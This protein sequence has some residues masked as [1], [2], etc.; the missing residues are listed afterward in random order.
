MRWMLLV[1]LLLAPVAGCGGS[2]QKPGGKVFCQSYE[3]N[4]LPECQRNC[5]EGK[6]ISNRE[7]IGECLKECRQDLIDDDTFNDR[8]PERVEILAA[9]G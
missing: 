9:E 7:A 5:E 8:C 2:Q 6:E 3:D 4:Y 1:A